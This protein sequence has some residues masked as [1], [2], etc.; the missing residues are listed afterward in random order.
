MVEKPEGLVPVLNSGEAKGRIALR[1]RGWM[2]PTDALRLHP[3]MRA[4][5]DEIAKQGWS[6]LFIETVGT[7]EAEV[8][9]GGSI[10]RMTSRTPP[11]TYRSERLRYY[12]ELELGEQTPTIT[13]VPEIS[14]F[15]VNVCSKS[16]PRAATVDLSKRLVTYIDDHF[17][18]WEKGW[19]EDKKKLS[20]A[21]EVREIAS[22]LLDVKGYKLD[23]PFKL[24]RYQEL[25]DILEAVRSPLFH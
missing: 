7:V 4:Q 25:K 3:E 18:R 10:F 20:D 14:E 13:S 16:F 21:R 5:L 1:S 24:E 8:V 2:Q 15:K 23:E 6:Y 9:L 22:W 12:L 17:W 19:E 11:G